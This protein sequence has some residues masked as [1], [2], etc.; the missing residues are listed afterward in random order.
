ML[1]GG[2]AVIYTIMKGAYRWDDPQIVVRSL[3]TGKQTVLVTGGSDGRYVSTGHLI[4]LRLGTLM[5]VPFDPVRLAVTGGATGVIDGVM[6]AANRNV[7]DMDNTLAAQFTVS[8]TGALVY[9]TGGVVAAGERSLAWLDRHGTSQVLPAPPR[10][11]FVPRL[12]A[13]G[14]RVAV[15]TTFVRQVWSF[16]IG[17]GALSSV[18]ADEQSGYGIF[19]PDGKRIVYRSGVAGGE[20][21][22]YWKAADG[23]GDVERLTTSPRSQTP[24]SWSPDGTTLAFVEEGDSKGFFQF[25]IWVVSIGDR[26]TRAV[27]HTVANEMTPEFSPD[28]GWLAY[29]SNESG[30]TEVYVQPYP[31]PGERHLISTNGGEQPAW[32][33]DGR[34]LFYVQR[35]LFNGGGQTT[36]MSV[37][38]ATTPAFL[39]GT[40]EALFASA[41]LG[42][43]WGRGYDVAPGWTAVHGHGQ[44]RSA[45]ESG[46]GAD[47]L[48]AALV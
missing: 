25:D 40:P 2:R 22:L 21:N 4:Y 23:S 19:T 29:A 39:A 47:D 41:A 24:S 6:Q 48:G 32:S 16:D 28:G 38:I 26:K 1:P 30:R 12:S 34:E 11:Y 10:P 35:G 14:Q 9:L 46:A 44:Q 33:R 31:G 3:E 5:A 15:S 43:A 18:T 36:L 17:R 8:D 42:T 45:N 20:D 37:K 7:S 13:D 27:I